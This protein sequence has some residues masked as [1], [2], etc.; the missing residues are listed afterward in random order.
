TLHIVVGWE[1]ERLLAGLSPLLPEGMRLHPIHN[2]DWQKQNGISLLAAAPHLP[3]PFLLLMGDHLFETRLLEAFVREADPAVLSL[4]VDRKIDCIFDLADAMKVAT[5]GGRID[6]IGKTLDRYDA[7]DT[8]IFVCPVEIFA[9]LEKVRVNDD[10]SLA[11]GVRA[12]AE[13]GKAR[14]ID[15]GDAWWQ[16]VDDGGMLREAETEAAVRLTNRKDDRLQTQEQAEGGD[17]A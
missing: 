4:A 3:V 9:Y 14:V 10:C 8:G 15:I 16:D 17:H 2:P 7:I 5:S 12:M 6:A 13:E 1:S 11:D